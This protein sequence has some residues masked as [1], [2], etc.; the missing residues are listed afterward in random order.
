MA[1]SATLPRQASCFSASWVGTDNRFSF[2][3]MQIDY[4]VGVA[5]GAD[6]IDVPSPGRS[7]GVEREQPLLGQRREELDR[8][9]RIAAGLLVHQL[10]QGPRALRLAMQGIGDEPANIVQPKRR[11]HDL[12]HPSPP[13]RESLSSVRMSG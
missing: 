13:P 5:P 7:D 12:L 10:R 2:S 3:T 11:Q 4:V 9:E 1:I 6:A 8:E